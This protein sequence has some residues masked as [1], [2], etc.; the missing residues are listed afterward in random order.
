MSPVISVVIP[1][2]RVDDQL[3]TQLAAV[4][5]QQIEEPFEVILACNTTDPAAAQRLRELASSIDARPVHVAVATQRRGASYARNAGAAM[6]TGEIL[7]FC[8]SDDIAHTTWLAPLVAGLS[9]ADAVGGRLVDFGLDERQAK[10]RPPATPDALPTFLGAPYIV[11]AS[12]AIRREVFEAAGGF[13]ETLIRCEDIALSWALLGKGYRLVFAA[14]SLMDYRHR[15]GLVPLLKQHYFYGRG[16]S[17]VLMRYGIPEPTPCDSA[18]VS[19][20]EPAEQAKRDLA[21]ASGRT[22]PLRP[23]RGFTEPTGKGLLRPNSQS[24]GRR[25]IAGTLRR[26]SLAAGRVVG[27]V[28]ERLRARRSRS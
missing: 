18:F 12:M 19:T 24:G 17:Q 10:I 13:D 26:G 11:S 14:D 4:V 25:S 27:I 3:E 5:A 6:A 2:G 7:A 15:P 20:A 9:S 28:E 22:D 1:V 16:M 23:M 21:E 8:D